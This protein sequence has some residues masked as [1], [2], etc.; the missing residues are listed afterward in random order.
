MSC[1]K[2]IIKEY[3][4][5]KRISTWILILFL[6]LT[7]YAIAQDDLIETKFIKISSLE[8]VQTDLN[9]IYNAS[10]GS[11]TIDLNKD[12]KIVLCECKGITGI[13]TIGKEHFLELNYSIPG[14]TDQKIE[15]SALICLSKGKLYNAL[16]CESLFDENTVTSSVNS[17]KLFHVRNIYKISFLS[18]KEKGG[19]CRLVI[20]IYN[21]NKSERDPQSNQETSDSV[22]LKFD[23]EKR[24]FFNDTVRLNG[25]YNITDEGWSD[26]I[27]GRFINELCPTV[28]LQGAQYLFITGAWY[29]KISNNVLV[30]YLNKC[31]DK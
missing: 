18:L 13:K 20:N 5:I 31:G 27:K 3:T 1:S 19:V 2:I 7:E 14:G 4:L 26:K 16:Q 8:N 29:S 25:D 28:N 10:D 9:I 23:P 15:Q 11:I 24:I 22:M 12:E 17:L 6:F 21:C 30:K